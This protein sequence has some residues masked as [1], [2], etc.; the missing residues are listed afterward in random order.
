MTVLPGSLDYLYY[1]GILDHIPY[2]AYETTPLNG[3]QYINQA[4]QGMLYDTYTSPDTFVRRNNT[5]YKQGENY[6]FAKSAFGYNDGVGTNADFEINAV[7]QEGKSFRQSL[8]DSAKSTASGFNNAPTF[9]K[10]LIAGGVMVGT[11]VCL[12][13]GKKK[14][15]VAEESINKSFFKKLNLKNWFKKKA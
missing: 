11:L 5:D 9:V 2:E 13:R 8:V 7:G 14:P 3:T 12:L 15:P 6:S 10:G 1:N 4:K